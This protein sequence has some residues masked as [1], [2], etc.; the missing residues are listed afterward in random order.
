MF[1]VTFLKM[2]TV[3]QKLEKFFPSS[4]STSSQEPYVRGGR[5]KVDDL[6]TLAS[7][8]QCVLK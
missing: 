8:F 2:R 4:T 7:T 1:Q 3:R 6:K 5:E